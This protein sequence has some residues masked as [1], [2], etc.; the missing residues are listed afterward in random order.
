[1]NFFRAFVVVLTVI[2]LTVA[3]A[4]AG[5]G[6]GAVVMDRQA[7]TRSVSSAEPGSGPDAI[8]RPEERAGV[9]AGDGLL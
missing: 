2:T 5:G 7:P 1:M 8:W 6:G 4:L 9:V 3:P